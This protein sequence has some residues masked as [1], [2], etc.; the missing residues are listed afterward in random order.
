MDVDFQ[1]PSWKPSA[2]PGISDEILRE[3]DKAWDQLLGYKEGEFSPDPEDGQSKP[4]QDDIA[5]SR[6]SQ[7]VEAR[8]ED[9]Q[10][11]RRERGQ[12]KLFAKDLKSA[13]MEHSVGHSLLGL[14]GYITSTLH[15]FGRILTSPFRW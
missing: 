9:L 11:R 10:R 3:G 5:E 8:K 13:E 1:E 4:S 14:A 7:E 15:W 12:A 2:S 6:S